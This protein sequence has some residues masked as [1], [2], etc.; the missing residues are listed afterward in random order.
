MHKY[1]VRIFSM[2]NGEIRFDFF[3]C[4]LVCTRWLTLV[5]FQAKPLCTDASLVI[6]NCCD[7]LQLVYLRNKDKG[8][9]KFLHACWN[10]LLP[11]QAGFLLSL[12]YVGLRRIVNSQKTV[13][14][15]FEGFAGVLLHV[16]P[17]SYKSL[18]RTYCCVERIWIWIM[19]LK[20]IVSD[21]TG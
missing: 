13:Y 4:L 2:Y 12:E 3:S 7:T 6:S 5:V 19:V 20:Y 18:N 21:D 14:S 17:L 1:I 16:T 10:Q 15:A 9:L 11:F 8:M